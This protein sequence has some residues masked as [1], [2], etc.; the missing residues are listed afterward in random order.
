VT[1]ELLLGID[2]GQTVCKAA[3]FDLQGREVAVTR[4]PNTVSSPRPRRLERD[5]DE[6]WRQ[7]GAAVRTA[8][9]R[10]EAVTGGPVRVLAVSVCGHGDGAYL[11]DAEGRPTRPAI[12]A[13]DSRATV[14]AAELRSGTV[15]EQA[16]AV[17]GQ[18]PFAGSPA[19]LLTWLKRHEPETL[20][21]SR[22]ALFCKDFLRLRLTGEVATDP[23]EACASFTDL[24]GLH[25]SPAALALYGLS[26]LAHLMP[27]VLDSA[28]PAGAVTAAAAAATGLA[29][30]TPVV[31]GAH[32]VDAAAIGI[33]A[34][35]D[36]D[37]SVVLGTF[38]INQVVAPAPV[39]GSAWQARLFA[40]PGHWLHMSTSPA[41]AS[42]LDWVLRRFGPWTA[43]GDPDPAAAIAEA[44]PVL[45]DPDRVAAAPL[46]LPFLFGAPGGDGPG[47]G[48]VGGRGWH[49]RADLL[50]AVVEGIAFNHR[51][52]LD[53]LRT[54]FP[55]ERPIRV[56]GGGARSPQ[57]TQL[58]ADAVGA[59]V[60][61]TD[62]DEAG[63]R[64]A[65]ILAG[66][67]SGCFTDLDD[68]VARTVRVVRRH[69][70]RPDRTA[71]LDERYRRYQAVVA[72]LD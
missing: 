55:M 57:W 64:G 27:P 41:G 11:V 47:A 17:T 66:I 39:A 10:A 50:Y 18:V 43:G 68:A 65:A 32:D 1:T 15:A 36:G 67:G 5:P 44:Q 9:R 3:L 56:C 37:Y 19:A 33:G 49:Q 31:T 69:D 14:E 48:W 72:A 25:W 53:I 24:E 2:S 52:H 38:S 46:F 4:L 22:W 70:P 61:I 63:G 60:E 20:A 45:E 8:L 34:H 28:A 35:R 71:V 12:L 58:L 40:W 62:A 7:V 6:V 26:D 54:R 21:R 16:L 13:T 30:G 51:T 59:P 23:T 42:N 29:V